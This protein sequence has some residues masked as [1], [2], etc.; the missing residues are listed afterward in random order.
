MGVRYQ[1]AVIQDWKIRAAIG[2]TVSLEI[3][4]ETL[5]NGA[6]QAT[7]VTVTVTDTGGVIVHG[8]DT[9]VPTF[10]VPDVFAF[11]NGAVAREL[12]VT[13]ESD[14]HY[15]MTK[16]T[17]DTALYLTVCPLQDQPPEIVPSIGTWGLIVLAGLLAVAFGWTWRRKAMKHPATP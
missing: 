5:D 3:L 13:I 7:T 1:E 16:T 4:T 8:P 10:G 14:G 9:R 11:A 6:N 2:E 15:Y 17:G 12:V